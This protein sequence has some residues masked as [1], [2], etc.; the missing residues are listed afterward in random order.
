MKAGTW[1]ADML[2]PGDILD[3]GGMVTDVVGEGDYVHLTVKHAG[4]EST[5]RV[6]R[7]APYNVNQKGGSSEG[8]QRDIQC[9][10][11][12]DRASGMD[13]LEGTEEAS[14]PTGIH[15]TSE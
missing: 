1:P 7:K 15:R 11:P 5:V 4:S 2:V 6:P 9:E 14:L 12:T 8:T 10:R 3:H 13:V